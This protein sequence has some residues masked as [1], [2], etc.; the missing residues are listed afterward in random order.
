M[1]DGW[2]ARHFRREGSTP[3]E[4][5]HRELWTDDSLELGVKAG[6]AAMIYLNG[7][8]IT[9]TKGSGGTMGCLPPR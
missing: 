7:G 2:I 9:Q 3:P 4:R 5:L 8:L 6:A 1:C